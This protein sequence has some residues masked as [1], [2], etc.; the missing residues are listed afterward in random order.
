MQYGAAVSSFEAL[1]SCQPGNMDALKGL[2]EVHKRRGDTHAS[3]AT[4]TTLIDAL[5]AAGCGLAWLCCV[6]V[7]LCVL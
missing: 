2:L 3:I 4:M 7:C 5:A 6:C 1:L